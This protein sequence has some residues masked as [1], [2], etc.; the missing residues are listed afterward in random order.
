M[1]APLL[2]AALSPRRTGAYLRDGVHFVQ[3]VHAQ[4]RRCIPQGIRAHRQ[5]SPPPEPALHDLHVTLEP[6][7]LLAQ[8]LQDGSLGVGEWKHDL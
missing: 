6:V 5:R 2:L 3:G 1:L 8:H 7:H 4:P